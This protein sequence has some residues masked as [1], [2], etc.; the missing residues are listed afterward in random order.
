VNIILVRFTIFM[1]GSVVLM[2]LAF[3]AAMGV[4]LVQWNFV[5]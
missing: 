4:G 5:H 2:I 3:H 1:I